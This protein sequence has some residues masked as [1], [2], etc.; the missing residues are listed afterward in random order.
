MFTFRLGKTRF[1]IKT[2]VIKEAK[3]DVLF[4]WTI[5]ALSSGDPRFMEIHTEGGSVIN[6]ECQGALAQFGKD[7][8]KGILAIPIGEA[9]LTG[10][11]ILPAKKI[12]HLITPNYRIKEENE[13]KTNLLLSGLNYAFALI[14][15]Y[16]VSHSP[17]RKILFT[18]VAERICGDLTD[19]EQKAILQVVVN[20]AKQYEFREVT[21]LCASEEEYEYYKRLFVNSF[22]PYSDRLY[23]K[24]FG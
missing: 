24:Y 8:G 21:I 22:I 13:N 1:N 19:A 23:M 9:I 18:P 5:P 15:E 7:D 12:L 6:K 4:N 17:L 20:N 11:G 16:S 3:G 10:A 2:T 14:N